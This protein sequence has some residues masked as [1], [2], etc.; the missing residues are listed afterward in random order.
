MNC[1]RSFLSRDRK[2][3]DSQRRDKILRFLSP[4]GNR[5]IFSTFWGHFLTESHRNPGEK[6]KKS[7]GD[8]I[9]KSPEE[10]L[11]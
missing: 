5:A 6:A 11:H 1:P 7:T 10:V 9:L 3:H 2:N 4:P 8:K